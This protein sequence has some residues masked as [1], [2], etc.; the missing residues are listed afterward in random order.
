MGN[1]KNIKWLPVLMGVTILG[2]AAFQIYWL[3]NTYDRE[4]RNWK[5]I[6]I[7]CFEKPYFPCRL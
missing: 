5:E 6:Q 3:K 2:I 4:K 1:F 7:C